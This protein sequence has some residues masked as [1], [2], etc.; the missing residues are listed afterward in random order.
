MYT[1]GNHAQKNSLRSKHDQLVGAAEFDKQRNVKGIFAVV[2]ERE[3]NS[4]IQSNMKQ[5]VTI[6]TEDI[7]GLVVICSAE[8]ANLARMT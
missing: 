3:V 7:F 8:A 5:E 1:C 2:P 6:M 4:Y